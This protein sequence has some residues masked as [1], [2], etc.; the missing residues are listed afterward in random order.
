MEN[1]VCLTE[2]L[3][4]CADLVCLW[5]V[6]WPEKLSFVEQTNLCKALEMV[7]SLIFIKSF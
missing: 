1:I 6:F 7:E 2:Y 4:K 3:Q 5:D